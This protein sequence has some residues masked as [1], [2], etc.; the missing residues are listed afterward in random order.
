[1]VPRE[2]SSGGKQKLLGIS[3]RGNHYLGRQFVQGARAVLRYRTKRAPGLNSW[4]SQLI[5]RRHP[6]VVVVALANKLLRMAWAVLCKNQTYRYAPL[7]T[8]L[9]TP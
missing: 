3:K 6:H 2:Y 9:T 4:L 5:A 8:E 1:M 7:A